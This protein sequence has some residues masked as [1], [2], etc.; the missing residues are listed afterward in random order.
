V[1]ASRFLL[2]MF[3]ITSFSLV[4]SFRLMSLLGGAL[5]KF[6]RVVKGETPKEEKGEMKEEKGLSEVEKE[7]LIMTC[8]I[9]SDRV[10][11]LK[12]IFEREKQKYRIERKRRLEDLALAE[13]SSSQLEKL[14][15]DYTEKEKEV[16]VMKK[17][18]ISARNEVSKLKVELAVEVRR[19]EDIKFE[20]EKKLKEAE[21]KIK[22][23]KRKINS[24]ESSIS[25]SSLSPSSK[26][27]RANVK[28]RGRT[29]K[30]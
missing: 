7:D 10:R 15:G 3:L 9:L 1:C 29:K 6:R 27:L 8:A 2:F 28:T 24:P 21:T 12:G 23:M 11:I 18:V 13:A 25:S 16:E 17:A 22:E 26:K 30:R 20:G 5:H 14:K 19:G 4:Q